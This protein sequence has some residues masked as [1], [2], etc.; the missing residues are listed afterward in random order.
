MQLQ[1]KK[2]GAKVGAT[3]R[4]IRANSDS[5]RDAGRRQAGVRG[6]EPVKS[7]CHLSSVIYHFSLNS[8]NNAKTK[9]FIF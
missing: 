3:L 2:R 4:S 1:D 6:C 5:L 7:I 8:M 9:Y